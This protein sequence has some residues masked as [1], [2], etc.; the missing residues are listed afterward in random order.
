MDWSFYL[1][2]SWYHWFDGPHPATVQGGGKGKDCLCLD[3]PIWKVIRA[4]CPWWASHVNDLDFGSLNHW[5]SCLEWMHQVTC[6]LHQ[7]PLFLSR[8]SLCRF[9]SSLL[10]S[11]NGPR[12]MRVA[13]CWKA[14]QKP[15]MRYLHSLWRLQGRLF[16]ACRPSLI[17]YGDSGCKVGGMW[18]L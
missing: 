3:P 18:G 17:S 11:R 1:K 9:W 8:L 6:L 12:L 4:T 15:S 14:R 5:Q 16:L 13:P 10:S 7:Y 2:L